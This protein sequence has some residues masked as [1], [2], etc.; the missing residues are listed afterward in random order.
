MGVLV[1]QEFPL[2]CAFLT[3]YPTSS[4][5]LQLVEA[6]TRNIVRDLRHHASLVVWCGGNEFSP[7]RNAPLVGALRQVVASEDPSRPFLAASPAHGDSHNWKVWHNYQPPAAYRNDETRFASEFGLQ[8]PPDEAS[9][10]G[11]VPAEELWPPGPSW[12]FHGAELGKL[13]RYARPFLQPK[14]TDLAAFIRASQHAQAQGLKLAIEHYRR[15][16]AHGCGGVLI[17]QLNEPW[18]A[19]SWALIDFYRKTK[20]A[21]DIVRRLFC[22]LLVSLDFPPRLYRAGDQIPIDIWIVND[23]TQTLAGC[24]LD[25]VL[26]DKTGQVVDRFTQKVDVTPDSAFRTA[27][28]TWTLPSGSGWKLTGQL[29]CQSQNFTFNEYDL[30][31]VDAIQPT[32]R[33]RLRTALTGL[34][35]PS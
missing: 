20:P 12:A 17:W 29:S 7:A 11:F 8:A 2:A 19:V 15:R 18:P 4:A 27:Q 6:E 21:Y 25:V 33:Q 1:W 32:L 31:T 24:E 28:V 26:W 3:R 10:R 5:Y 30:T 23:R 16:K 34:F 9:L 22:P 35:L 13:R 14:E